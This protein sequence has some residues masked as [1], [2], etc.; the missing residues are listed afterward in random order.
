MKGV[1]YRQMV[2]ED[3]IQVIPLSAG[4]IQERVDMLDVASEMPVN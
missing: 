2:G 3:R 4:Q 1:I